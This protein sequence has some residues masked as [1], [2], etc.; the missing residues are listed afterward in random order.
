LEVSSTSIATTVNAITMDVG[1]I[2][3]PESDTKMAQAVANIPANCLSVVGALKSIAEYTALTAA[4]VLIS[5]EFDANPEIGVTL[6]AGD[7]VYLS[8]T[9]VGKVT[10]VAP[11]TTGQCVME[12][13]VALSATKVLLRSEF[14][15]SIV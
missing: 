5:G 3:I 8:A 6:V 13:G 2:L 9:H 10:N 12:I 7:I 1:D 14:K 15:Y 4:V 11:S